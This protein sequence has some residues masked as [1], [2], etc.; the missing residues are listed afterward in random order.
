MMLSEAFVSRQYAIANDQ[1]E[2]IELLKQRIYAMFNLRGGI[3]KTTHS[4]NLSYL[5]DNP[6]AADTCP[7][8]R[9]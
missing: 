6:L 9:I 8:M 3:G 1:A 2:D 7:Q 4:F 5:V